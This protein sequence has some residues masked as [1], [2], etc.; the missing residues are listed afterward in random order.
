MPT[1]VLLSIRPIFANAILDG[2]KTFELRRSVFRRRGIRKVIIYASSPVRRVIGEFRIDRIL[3]LEPARLWTVVAKGAGIDRRYFDEYF[4][5]R[6]K[7]FA[8]KVYRP[9]R[10]VTPLQLN[11]R[12]GLSRPPQSFCYVY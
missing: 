5:G 2:T 1:D 7:G 3:E 10:Y 4:R 9:R 11:E 12:F 8:L 6:K